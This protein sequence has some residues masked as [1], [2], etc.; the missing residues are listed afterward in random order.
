MMKRTAVNPWNWSLKYSFN[1][2]EVIEGVTRYL[3]CS[4][5][6]ALDA[7]GNPKHAGDMRA[8]LGLALDNLEKVL[9]G[10][11]MTLGN[12]VRFTIY[13][14]DVDQAIANWEVFA[15]R[16]GAAGV[17]PPQTLL[18]VDRLAFPELMVEV[19]A[20]AVA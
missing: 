4:G 15:E 5:Q 6:T 16:I 3:V 12:V 19:E 14:T 11:G 8:Q 9:S 18:G 20:T 1:Q 10:A 17:M 13:A 2:A 7:D